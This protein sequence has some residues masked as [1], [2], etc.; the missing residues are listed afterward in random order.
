MITTQPLPAIDPATL[1]LPALRAQARALRATCIQLAHDGR[2]GH[3]NGALSSVDLVQCLFAGWMR[4][5]PD[6]TERDR[7]IFSKGHACTSLYAV[8]AAQGLI[9]P[10]HLDRYAQDHTPLPSHPCIH[11][12]PQLDAS[13]GSLGHGL[14]VG[15]GRAY[16]L[17][18]KRSPA[19]VAVL[20]S[21]GECNEGSTWE[22]AMFAAANG[23]DNLLCVVDYNRVQSV[24]RTDELNGHTRFEDKFRAFGWQVL[25]IDGHD[26]GQILGALAQVPRLPGRPTAIVAHTMAGK[27]VSFMQDQVLWHYRVPSADDLARALAELDARPLHRPATAPRAAEPA[28]A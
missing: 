11:A 25:S 15:S 2:E 17:K 22:A 21:D 6:E 20:L 9:P 23:L 5:L 1:D 7:F 26:H 12:L 14:N 10:A 3:L 4:G 18:A 8:L 13:A 24:G 19:R 27:G 16:A 28:A